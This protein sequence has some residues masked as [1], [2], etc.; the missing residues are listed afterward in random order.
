MR[1]FWAVVKREYVQRVRSRMFLVVTVGAPL[2]FALFTV[3]PVLMASIK[4]GGPTRVA[5]SDE[6]GRMFERVRDALVSGRGDDDE[7]EDETAAAAPEAMNQNSRAHLEQMAKASEQG[8]EVERVEAGGRTTEEIKAQLNGRVSRGELDAYIILPRDV[9]GGGEAQYYARNVGD[10]FTRGQVRGALVRAAREARLDERGI[11]PEV[12]RAVNQPLRVK[13]ARAGGGG[14]EDKGQAFWLVFGVG[15]VIYLTILMYGQVILG[16]IIEEKET[17]IAEILFSSIRS[18]PL[19]FGKMIGVSLV[20]LT[21][22]AIWGLAL[23]ALSLY[24][25]AT[26]A[27]RGG[28]PEE[29]QL[30]IPASVYAYLVLFFL[31]GYFIY[32]SLYAL[33]GSMVTTSQEGGQLA[34]PIIIV[35]VIGFYMAFPVIRSPGSPFAFWISLVPFFAPITMLI[36]IV[37]QTPPFWQIALSLAIGFAT[38]ALLLWLAARVYRVGMLMYGKRATI[39]EV[40]RWIRRP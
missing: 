30:N 17:R 32:A 6:T 29:F 14:E 19:M 12:M 1:K 22:F 5:V 2:M 38:V 40:L 23:A 31:L 39:P 37:T 27:G 8:F 34:M 11:G 26:L 20:A 21:Q 15:F 35:L 25:A 16:A 24:G 9:L 18:F 28:L 33:V 13:T 3:V 36:R 10:V 4:T 7:D